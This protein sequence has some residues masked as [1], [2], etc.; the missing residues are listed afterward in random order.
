LER[1]ISAVLV[2]A[3]PVDADGVVLPSRLD[4]H[5]VPLAVRLRRS[6]HGSLERADRAGPVLRA[7]G[8]LVDLDLVPGADRA[9]RVVPGIGEPHEHA[10]VVIGARGPP[11]GR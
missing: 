5:V 1:A 4:F 8:G 11:R 6:A 2:D 9:P 3:P 7:R 10:R